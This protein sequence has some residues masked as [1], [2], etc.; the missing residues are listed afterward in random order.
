MYNAID[1]VGSG[2]FAAG[3]T[4]FGMAEDGVDYSKSNTAELTQD[5]ID[6]LEE[7]KAQIIAGDI[8]V[9]EDP[10]KV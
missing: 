2:T 5:I 9:P 8:V 6:Q 4:V 1:Q 10:T 3:A 7:Y